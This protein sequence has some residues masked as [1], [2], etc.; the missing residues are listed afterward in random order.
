MY[1]PFISNRKILSGY[2]SIWI[3]VF[4]AHAFVLF[5]ILDLELGYAVMDAFVFNAVYFLLGIGI[6]YPTK[7]ISFENT[8]T[9]RII[10]NHIA[11]SLLTAGI[12][13]LN[14]YL[15]LS[16]LYPEQIEFIKLSLVWRF[17]IG[18]L[19]YLVIVSISYLIIYYT[20]FQEKEVKETELNS[21]IKEAE[22]KSLKYQINPHF[23]FNS[24]NSISSLT[25]TSPDRAREMTIKLSGFLRATLSKNEKQK[26]KLIDELANVK[27]YLD[28]EKVRFEDKFEFVEEIGE[29]CG[30]TE[31]PSMILQPLFENA[32]K[33]GVYESLEK[34][35]IKISCSME[36][37]YMKIIVENNFDPESVANKGE[38]IGLSNIK[39]RLKLIYNQNNLI[40]IDKNDNKFKVNIF[41]PLQNGAAV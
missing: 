41:I 20:H 28:I 40:S 38:G 14:G 2:L 10:L 8:S 35:T 22:L 33:Y 15:I 29:E 12:W 36:E 37:E 5:N 39:N 16:N 19:F 24:L 23:I 3:L 31:V 30:Q 25:I 34:V 1:N 6:W 27:L 11:G 18:N 4:V 17:I 7:Y 9:I 32:I 26:A 21:L 13:I